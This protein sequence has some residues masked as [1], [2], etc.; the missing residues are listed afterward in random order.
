MPI[1]FK[2]LI[3]SEQSATAG[4]LKFLPHEASGVWFGALFL[5]D[6]RGE[7][8]EFTHARIRPPKALLWRPVDIQAY[9]VRSMCVSMFD[10]CPASPNIILCIANEVPYDV[11]ARDISIDLPVA[12]LSAKDG[13]DVMAEWIPEPQDDAP[14]KHIYETLSTRGLLV[15]PFER[16][17]I[18]L[19]EVYSDLLR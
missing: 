9:C 2:N 5:M 13:S 11:F 10:A 3:D 16:A 6:A 12:R 1:P 17:E 7:P 18:G 4:Y 19:R 8:I 15:E 14:A